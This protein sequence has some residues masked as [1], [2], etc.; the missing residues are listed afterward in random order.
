MADKKKPAQKALHVVIGTPD[1]DCPLCKA[2]AEGPEAFMKAVA[3]LDAQA[4]EGL[5]AEDLA[6]GGKP[7][8][9]DT[10]TPERN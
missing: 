2:A 7:I 5:K 4:V 10:L 9:L 1:D 8:V 3:A 6:Q